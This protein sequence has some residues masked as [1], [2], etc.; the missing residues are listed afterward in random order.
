MQREGALVEIFERALNVLE[1]C[2]CKQDPQKD[3]CYHCLY[4]YRQS[5]KIGQ[6]S[7]NTA[8]RLLKQ[9]L[10]QSFEQ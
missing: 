5:Q 1:N 6:I 2:T 3:G 9:I 7:R 10:M 4:A 8:T